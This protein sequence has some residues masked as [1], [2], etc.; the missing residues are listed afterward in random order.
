MKSYTISILIGLALIIAMIAWDIAS[1]AITLPGGSDTII[2]TPSIQVWVSGGNSVEIAQSLGIRILGFA[3]VLISGLALVYI[4]LMWVYMVVFSESEERI[5]TQKKQI[6]YVLIGFLFI[7]IPGLAYQIFIPD[8]KSGS[9]G[10]AIGLWWDTTWGAVFWNTT[11]GLD[12]FLYNIVAFLKVFIFGIAVLIFTWGLFQ[13]I[14]SAGDD[15]K[16]KMARNRLLYGILGLIFLG[17]VE[18]WWALVSAGNF[19]TNIVNGVSDIGRKLLGLS[20]FFA[21]PI[22]IFMLI[23]AGYYY[24]TSGGDEERIKKAKTIII[25]TCIA[26]VIL[27]ASLSFITELINF[28]I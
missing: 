20:L 13:L 19:S 26:A 3:K 24:I 21:A 9:I 8:N 22:A 18:A 28:T 14:L 2:A 23:W 11:Y 25:N 15:E 17:F 27:I 7:N 1:A 6:V 4:V 5:K 10:W 16:K 12:P